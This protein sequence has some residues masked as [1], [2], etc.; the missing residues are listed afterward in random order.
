MLRRRDVGKHK[1]EARGK[2]LGD[3]KTPICL[4]DC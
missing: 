1:T 3:G 2:K 4:S